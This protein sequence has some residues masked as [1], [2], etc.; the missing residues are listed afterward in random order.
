MNTDNQDSHSQLLSTRRGEESEIWD[1][2]ALCAAK[3][4]ISPLSPPFPEGKGD[5]GIGREATKLG[6]DPVRADRRRI[7]DGSS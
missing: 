4:Q 5:G 6:C 7:F 2:A 3:S 1:F